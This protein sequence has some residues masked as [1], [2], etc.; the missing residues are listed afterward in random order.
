MNKRLLFCLSLVL[1]SGLLVQ[2]EAQE[3]PPSI[4]SYED[5][6]V[7]KIEVKIENLPKGGSFDRQ[8]VIA[9]LRTREGDPYSQYVFDQDLKLLADEYDYV[10]PQVNV[11][12]DVVDITLKIYLRPFIRS[13]KWEGNQYLKTSTLQK[14]LDIKPGI[15]FNRTDFNK[16]FSK[17]KEYYLKKGYFESQL[18][19]KLVPDPET[20]EADIV[21]TIA[22]GRSGKVDNIVFHGFTKKE[23]SDI[24][25]K[26]Y[27]KKYSTLTSWFTGMG[28][29]NEEALEQDRLMI[30]NYLQ[31]EGFADARVQIQIL[32]SPSKGKIIVDIT[33]DKGVCYNFGQLSFE[34]NILFTDEE[35]QQS[36]LARPD[37]T[38]SPEKLRK[39]A[40]SIKELYGRKGY[41]DANVTFETQL[42][43]DCPIYNAHFQIDE[44]NEFRI[45]MIRVIGNIQTE[46]RVILRESLLVPGDGFD[47][48]RLKVTQA[49]LE[50]IGYF[51]TV[52][53][54][55]VRTQDDLS[56]G[57]NYRDIYI[58]VEEKQTGSISLFSGFSRADNVYG[59]LDLTEKNFNYK[60]LGRLFKEGISSVRGG[61]EF[62]HMRASFGPTQQS[63]LVNWLTPYFYDTYWRIGL[64]F[65]AVL[66]SQLQ[67]KDYTINT[68]NFG[69]TIAYPLGPYLSYGSRYRV[70]NI[71]IR[72]DLDNKQENRQ[73]Q[74]NNGI[75]SGLSGF[76]TYDSCDNALKPH[77][78]YRSSL[79]AEIVGLGGH[80]N[81]FRAG[82]VNAYY[83]PLWARGY[84]RYRWE[85]RFIAPFGKSPNFND[86]PLSERFFL[87]GA[88]SVRGYKDFSLGPEYEKDAPKGGI[89]SSM[90]T[91]DYIQEVASFLDIFAFIDAG[92]VSPKVFQIGTYQMSYGIGANVDVLGRFPVTL[93]YG[94]PINARSDQKQGFFFSMG[95]QF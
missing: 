34:G 13:I 81:F 23:E 15:L 80:F 41:I 36:F 6:T 92:F 28:N 39:T 20:Q 90:I 55:A 84:M 49:R 21:I 67:S 14:E 66:N 47:S 22:E 64:E 72:G 60:G 87:G 61:G 63:Y 37:A 42:V 35:I 73:I 68:Y 85:F 50:S 52:N 83:T 30:F 25:Q 4:Q 32:E 16:A 33:A 44:G 40:E 56:L 86:I 26:F 91:L 8:T 65:N 51:K 18:T 88:A 3:S 71:D 11:T 93:G 31:D 2:A 74:N 48:L 9:K 69:A 19:Y 5:R 78:G 12:G 1:S 53:V 54:Y 24:L 75:L 45:G 38:Y 46:T 43:Q 94:F 70:R 17:V 79:E 57:D 27:T 10:D 77:R 7:G 29:F 58:E 59:G 95:G 76:L 82:Y 62:L 89:S